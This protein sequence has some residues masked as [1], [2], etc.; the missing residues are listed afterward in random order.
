[1][2]PLWENWESVY[3]TQPSPGIAL[4]TEPWWDV[5]SGRLARGVFYTLG[6]QHLDFLQPSG[7]SGLTGQGTMDWMEFCHQNT[8]VNDLRCT[9]CTER[10]AGGMP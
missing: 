7:S 6:G 8:H 10:P 1:M 9:K 2:A 3:A 5:L 4:H